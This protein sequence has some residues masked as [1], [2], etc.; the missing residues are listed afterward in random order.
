VP[1]YSRLVF[2]SAAE[3]KHALVT[4]FSL[5]E[6]SAEDVFGLR[7]TAD[8]EIDGVDAAAITSV[9]PLRAPTLPRPFHKQQVVVVNL[10]LDAMGDNVHRAKQVRKIAAQLAPLGFC[11]TPPSSQ[12]TLAGGIG[13]VAC[14]DSNIFAVGRTRQREALAS[15]FGPITALGARLCEGSETTGSGDSQASATGSTQTMDCLACLQR[16]GDTHFFARAY[17]PKFP[18]QVA[19][20]AGRLGVEIPGLFDIVATDLPVLARHH[21][22]IMSSDHDCVGATVVVG[23]QL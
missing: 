18:Q 3:R 10:H 21:W 16:M 23:G 1:W 22:Q 14:G 17:E 8:T 20:A 6:P 19:V 11:Y 7:E 5:C 4:V 12:Q 15:A 13:F 9:G 2:K